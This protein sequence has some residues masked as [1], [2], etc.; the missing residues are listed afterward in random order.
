MQKTAPHRIT[1]Y[2]VLDNF[3]KGLF[4]T[5]KEDFKRIRQSE[6]IFAPSK[7]W[8]PA[9]LRAVREVARSHRVSCHLSLEAE[10]A[11][12]LGACLG[13]AVE[14]PAASSASGGAYAHVCS[15]GPVFDAEEIWP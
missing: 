4:A 5:A 15:D 3:N 1:H 2:Y 11:C 10:M 14:R 9:M 7:Y 6:C 8:R 12:G 13:C